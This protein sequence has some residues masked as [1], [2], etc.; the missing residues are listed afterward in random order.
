MLKTERLVIKPFEPEDRDD[1]IELLTSSEIGKTYMLPEFQEKSEAEPLFQKLC[2]LSHSEEHY[3][4]GIYL[5]NKLIGFLND[6]EING[7]KIEMGYVIHPD[8]WGK[9]LGTEAFSA[10]IEDLF[11]RG[12]SQVVAGAF[13]E[14]TAS[15][16]VMEKCGMHRLEQEEDLEYRGKTFRCVYYGIEKE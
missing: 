2:K 16:R 5:E 3:Q 10:V 8:H 1:A 14:N 12:F 4:R 6:V 15:R 11:R 9:G 13:S 7:G